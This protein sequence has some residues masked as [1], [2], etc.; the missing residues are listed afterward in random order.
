M[1]LG[2]ILIDWSFFTEEEKLAWVKKTSPESIVHFIDSI[3]RNKLGA[4]DRLDK[5]LAEVTLLREQIRKMPY[6]FACGEKRI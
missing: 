4:F 3:Q 5:A 1:M 2:V 6:L